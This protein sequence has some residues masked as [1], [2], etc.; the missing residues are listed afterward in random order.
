MLGF[1]RSLVLLFVYATSIAWA[2]DASSGIVGRQDDDDN[3]TAPVSTFLY[4]ASDYDEDNWA[5]F[6]FAL[7]V[8]RDSGDMWFKMM[9]PSM[10][11]WMA[12]GTG[13]Q[14]AGSMMFIAYADGDDDDITLSVRRAT[15]HNEPSYDS[16]ID[17]ELLDGSEIINGSYVINGR[18]KSCADSGK[19]DL[20]STEFPFIFAFGPSGFAINSGS[21][22][23][24]IR[25]HSAYG[26][27][28]LDLK[29]ATTDDDDA[30][31]PTLEDTLDTNNI[32]T[33]LKE[34]DKAELPSRFHALVMCGSFVVLFPI[35]V[36]ILRVLD[37]VMLHGIF[38]GIAL[39]VVCAGV[40]VGIWISKLYNKSKSFSSGHQVYGLIV[41]VLLFIQWGLGFVHHL[42]YKK[43]Q[44]PTILGK[45]HLYCGPGILVMGLVNG[46]IGFRF[47]GSNRRVITYCIVV[48]AMLL[49]V[50]GVL[51]LQRRKKARK[52]RYMGAPGVPGGPVGVP[53]PYGGPGE[54]AGGSSSFGGGLASR[55]GLGAGHRSTSSQSDIAL[56]RVP[57]QDPPPYNT[58]PAQEPRSM[59]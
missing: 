17:F 27:F 8:G 52:A 55:F 19:L 23:A 18:C 14:M 53:P 21:S 13:N 25:R 33:S 42:L 15:G 40:G 58:G 51:F 37:R 31:V 7:T 1:I 24:G 35:G 16:N 45:I 26:K 29:A 6:T 11:S 34:D 20:D 54:P 22:S 36:L 4:K 5:N 57:S 44:R 9:G 48:V 43:H 38:Q 59:I 10:Y 41:F 12:V 2:A 47:A 56:N 50:G 3:S 46:A 30:T 28:K 32:G 49:I 39:L